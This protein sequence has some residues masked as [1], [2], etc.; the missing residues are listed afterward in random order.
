MYFL[1]YIGLIMTIYI[2]TF[3][4]DFTAEHTEKIT[5]FLAIIIITL[6]IIGVLSSLVG[7]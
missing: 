7:R 5:A 3:K 1:I 2:A 4:D 6:V